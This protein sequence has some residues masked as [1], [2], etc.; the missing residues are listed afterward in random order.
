V[1]SALPACALLVLCAAAGELPPPPGVLGVVDGSA[2]TA[3]DLDRW[4]P[5]LEERRDLRPHRFADQ[6]ARERRFVEEVALARVLLA[7][8]A[9]L[10]PAAEVDRMW[11][12]QCARAVDDAYRGEVLAVR[13]AVDLEDARAVWAANRGAS[14]GGEAAGVHEIFLW[15]PKDL[16]ELRRERQQLLAELR[17]QVGSL[18]DFKRLASLHSDA[19]SSIA[20]GS[21]GTIERAGVSPDLARVLFAGRTGSSEV[22]GT[23]DGLYLFYV[24]RLI[25][26][27][28]ERFEEVADRI[29]ERLRR[30]QLRALEAGELEALPARRD[31]ELRSPDQVRADG[32]A[33]R[34]AGDEVG[35]DRLAVDPSALDDAELARRIARAAATDL[36]RRELERL[37]LCPAD[38]QIERLEHAVA[39]RLLELLVRR[40]WAARDH[41]PFLA[42]AR[43]SLAIE[44]RPERW[45]FDLLLVDAAARPR[46][47][48]DLFRLRHELG[49]GGSLAALSSRLRAELGVAGELVEVRDRPVGELAGLGPEIFNTLRA[50]DAPG[51][52]SKPLELRSEGQIAMVQMR[53]RR[54][55][56][57]AAAAE[58]GAAV[59]NEARRRLAEE[60]RVGLLT[61]HC[62]VPVAP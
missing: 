34:L 25:P 32:I 44:P 9:A 4:R 41:G 57:A 17:S 18:E 46:L 52:I 8:H 24:S 31:L 36:R 16:P 58:L 12:E 7:H 61:A 60:V 30:D 21:L 20:G 38:D 39:Q 42:A 56:E 37:G 33:Y 49:E 59:E 15:A 28:G 26:A 51:P 43:A 35:L 6:A 5:L 27:R 3:A 11:V 40:E 47:I 50:T 14:A 22:V 13:V 1:T 54:L 19:T 53:D 48:F 29:L 55:D 2:V 23:A 10:L 45:S 62:W